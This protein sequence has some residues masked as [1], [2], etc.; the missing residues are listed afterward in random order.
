MKNVRL[1]EAAGEEAAVLSV[2]SE[3]L[4]GDRSVLDVAVRQQ[5]QV[6][7]AGGWRQQ[8]E[9]PERPPQLSTAPY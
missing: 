2:L 5:Q 4:Q 9:R 3:Q 8:A 7:D 1:P 6:T